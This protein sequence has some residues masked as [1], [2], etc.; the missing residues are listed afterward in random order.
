[1]GQ[2]RLLSAILCL[3]FFLWAAGAIPSPVPAA[4]DP[5]EQRAERLK[6]FREKRDRFFKED[7]HSPLKEADRKKFKGLAYFPINV[8]YAKEGLIEPFPTEP[9][10]L[11]V[12]LRTNKGTERRYV[13]HGRFKFKLDGKDYV[14]YVYRSLG[15]DEL[16]LPFKDETAGKE[17]FPTGRYLF[18]EP[19][20][21][22]KVLIDFNRA[23]NPFCAYNEAYMCPLPPKENWL[24]I[25]IRA[26]EKRFR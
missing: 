5:M 26:G 22:G 7:P 17:T 10:P 12:G 11:V 4:S 23:Y 6:V 16:F 2:K 18:I 25:P 9:G 8:K 15:T 1:M 24:G 21:G 20:P 19:M 13:K 14:L 3:S